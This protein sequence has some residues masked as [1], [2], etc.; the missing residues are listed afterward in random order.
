MSLRLAIPL[1]TSLVTFSLLGCGSD[2]GQGTTTLRPGVED[3]SQS[4]KGTPSAAESAFWEAVRNGDDTGREEAANKMRADA[5]RDPATYGY[6]AF[7]AGANSF[8]HPTVLLRAQADGTTLPQGQPRTPDQLADAEQLLT[9]GMQNLTDPLYL[10]FDA[11]FL[12]T[13]QLGSGDVAAGQQ[14]FALGMQ[15]NPAASGFISV[16]FKLQQQDVPGALDAFYQL[17]EY[18]SGG[19]VDHGGAGA[20]AYVARANA[21]TLVH[22]ECY[23]GYHA[24]HGTEGILLLVGDVHAL[25]GDAQAAGQYYAAAQAAKNFSSWPLAPLLQRRIDGTEPPSL[26]ATT[27]LT[28]CGS[29]HTNTLP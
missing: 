7:L 15:K 3:S 11:A 22:R 16:I 24:T 9:Q 18:C 12:A 27:G 13:L 2:A 17:I 19:P 4:Y 23:S 1:V 5:Q 6:S 25:N 28:S 26:G 8:M 29:C 20:G 21:A 14:S 10:G